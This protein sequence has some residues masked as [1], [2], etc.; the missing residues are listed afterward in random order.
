MGGRH[1]QSDRYRSAG[2]ARVLRGQVGKLAR[3]TIGV[4]VSE[5]KPTSVAAVPDWHVGKETVKALDVLQ[6]SEELPLPA[7]DLRLAE[8]LET[9]PIANL[10]SLAQQ[11]REIAWRQYGT[12]VFPGYDRVHHALIRRAPWVAVEDLLAGA[13]WERAILHGDNDDLDLE[14]LLSRTLASLYQS[15][16]ERVLAVFRNLKS[17]RVIEDT[18]IFQK[19]DGQA[20]LEAMAAA[21]ESPAGQA[22]DRA[23]PDFF[24][25]RINEAKRQ[26]SAQLKTFH[27]HPIDDGFKAGRSVTY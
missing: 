14:G 16:P 12:G 23:E 2:S 3:P 6:W 4:E 10:R 21:R 1:C 26:V 5:T 25:S 19:F 17:R 27:R 15:E 20:V 8:A 9:M 18:S 24:L 11:Y 7:F 13:E 22:L